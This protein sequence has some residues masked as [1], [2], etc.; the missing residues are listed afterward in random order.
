MLLHNFPVSPQT[1]NVNKGDKAVGFIYD[2]NTAVG[3]IL[4]LS[5][6][7]LSN[8]WEKARSHIDTNWKIDNKPFNIN[9][10]FIAEWA[11]FEGIKVI[12]MQLHTQL[13]GNKPIKM[14]IISWPVTLVLNKIFCW[15]DR[16]FLEYLKISDIM[17]LFQLVLIA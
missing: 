13:W 6:H 14:Q 9:Q 1:W 15:I 11:Q 17:V 3:G 12:W 8:L 7:P 5:P 4:P 2:H 10:C 16:F